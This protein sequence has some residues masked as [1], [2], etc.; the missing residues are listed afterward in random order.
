[1]LRQLRPTPRRWQPCAPRRL[2]LKLLHVLHADR[3][4]RRGGN[5]LRDLVGVERVF[6][7]LEP[8]ERLGIGRATIGR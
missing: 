4:G 1:M 5:F 7:H 3:E 8:L 6:Y 2:A